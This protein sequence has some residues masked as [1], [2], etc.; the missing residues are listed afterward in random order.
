MLKFLCGCDRRW[1]MVDISTKTSESCEFCELRTKH[2]LQTNS[3][4]ITHL[5]LHVK[6]KTLP[7]K[8]EN[9]WD[10]GLSSTFLDLI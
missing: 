9:P 4:Q 2:S 5:Y 10:L 1:E 3:K 6:Y 8:G 7:K